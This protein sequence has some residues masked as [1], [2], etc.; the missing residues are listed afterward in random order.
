[1]NQKLF[2][3]EKKKHFPC[4][5]KKGEISRKRASVNQLEAAISRPISEA[6]IDQAD[7]ARPGRDSGALESATRRLSYRPSGPSARRLGRKGVTRGPPLLNAQWARIRA[8][9]RISSSLHAAAAAA[10]GPIPPSTM[11]SSPVTVAHRWRAR[12]AT[13]RSTGRTSCRWKASWAL[14][15]LGRYVE[16]ERRCSIAGAAVARGVR[17]PAVARRISSGG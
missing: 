14:N 5:R 4:F 1:M 12:P 8:A 10:P 16:H 17:R 11:G 3:R 2:S 7:R 9:T 15:A 6:A 13:A